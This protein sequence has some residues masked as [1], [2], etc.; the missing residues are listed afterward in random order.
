MDHQKILKTPR[1]VLITDSQRL[2]AERFFEAVDAALGGGVDAV[3]VRE[4]HMDSARLLSFASA[5]RELTHLHSAELIVHSQADVAKA[6][7]ADGVHLSA[8]DMNQIPPMKAWINDPAVRF[9]T[10]CHNEIE[11]EFAK[12]FEA[13]FVFLSPV[14][15]TKSHPDEE[16][17]GIT[18]FRELSTASELPVVALGG[19]TPQNRNQLEGYG[20]AVI[21]AIL[22]V[23]DSKA[24]A[25]T[26]RG[27]P[28]S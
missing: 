12:R 21:S 5:L 18:R 19:I 25:S 27:E 2:P 22:D 1:L 6:V 24:A 13:D 15:A 8:M 4:K 14:F 17:L 16:P 9:S 7:Q 20:V 11:L 23:E 10:S 28:L 26:L 3:L